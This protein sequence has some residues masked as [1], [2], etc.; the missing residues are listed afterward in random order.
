LIVLLSFFFTFFSIACWQIGYSNH[1]AR[2]LCLELAS[3]G[4]S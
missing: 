1:A 4:L 2:R 3:H